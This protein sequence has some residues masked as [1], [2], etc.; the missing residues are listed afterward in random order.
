MTAASQTCVAH[1]PALDGDPWHITG[2]PDVGSLQDGPDHEIVDHAIWQAK[3]RSWHVLACVRKTNVGRV[4]Y[5]WEGSSLEQTNW[6][7]LG[8]TMRADHRYGESV[9]DWEIEEW[10]QAPYVLEDKGTYYMFYGGHNSEL[11]E[12]QI[13]LATSPDGRTWTRQRNEQGYSRVFVGPGEARDPM[14]LRMGDQWV[15]YNCGHDTGK[16]RPC[17]VF[18]RTSSDLLHWSDARQVSWGGHAS[19]TG[20]GSAECPFVVYVDGY[21]YLFRTSEYRT[22]ART[23]VYR[24]QDPFDFGLGNDDKWVATLRVAAPE[25]VLAGDKYYISSVEDLKGGIQL[26]KLKWM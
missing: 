13:C 23:H 12:C 17:K 16:R 15:C 22:P 18:A 5:E 2:Y 6:K 3:D 20:L 11:G 24:S 1:I 25:L 8:V 14:V 19:G 4:L 10:L 26:F 9:N 7:P 21:Y